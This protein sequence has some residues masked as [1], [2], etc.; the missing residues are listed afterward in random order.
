MQEYH[1]LSL[2]SG[3]PS[4]Y[5]EFI[6]KFK[7]G[8]IRS[9]YYCQPDGFDHAI[10]QVIDGENSAGVIK[11]SEVVGYLPPHNCIAKGLRDYPGIIADL[12]RDYYDDQQARI[13]AEDRV[14]YFTAELELEIWNNPEYRNEVMRKAARTKQLQES[15]EYLG[16]ESELEKAKN[17]EFSSKVRLDRHRNEFAVQKLEYRNVIAKKESV[18]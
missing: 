5:G 14:A 17:R 7:D 3:L 6:F 12:D 9:G 4:S 15:S 16:L 13:A 11:E 2:V 8:S 1:Q 18:I 10:V